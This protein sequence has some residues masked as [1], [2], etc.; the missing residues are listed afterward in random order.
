MGGLNYKSGMQSVQINQSSC[1]LRNTLKGVRVGE[2]VGR[3]MYI[4]S[5]SARVKNIT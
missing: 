5:I 4:N 1:L 3:G 2:G